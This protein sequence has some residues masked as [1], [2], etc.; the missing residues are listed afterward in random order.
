[1]RGSIKL[2][3]IF[4]ISINI[5]V[6]F[7]LLFLLV[8]PSGLKWVFLVFGV[9]FFVTVHE[10]C[11]SLV[12]KY[13]GINVS[14]IT[15]LPIGGVAS[16]A[17]IPEKPIQELLISLAGPASNI[18]ILVIFFFP[19]KYLLGDEILFHS[20]SA[21]TWKLAI[22][23]LYWINLALAGFNLLPA[24]PMDG[25]RVLR[26]LLATRMGYRK[27]TK[28]AVNLGHVF[29]LGFAYFG[30]VRLNIVL[31]VIAV[32][33]YMAASSE[34][35]QVDVKEALKKFRVRDILPTNF[36]TVKSN[37]TLA[38]VLELVFHSHQ[39]DFPVVDDGDAVGFATRQDIMAGVHRF[40]MNTMV[41][42]VMRKDFPKV[43]DS[44]ALMKVQNIMQVN[45]VRVLPVM[46]DNKVIGV[47]TLEDI[48]RVY[49][50]VS[51]KG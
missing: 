43:K 1:M 40:G 31:I 22:A 29:A 47:I 9:F 36:Y 44:D 20:L 27:A 17:K 39:E 3:K 4:G 16:M 32:F 19:M 46:R 12:A 37:T 34:E 18:A 5:H 10:L 7:F 41:K 2:F 26:A 49:S 14:E 35:M 48:G 51:Q 15:L 23:Y 24:F 13:F 8:L 33:I 42:D 21:G 11:H 50:M 6:T 45:N 38:K 28:I 25:G 30:F